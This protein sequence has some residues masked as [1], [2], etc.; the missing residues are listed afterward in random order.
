[1]LMQLMQ[2]RWSE[3]VTIITGRSTIGTRSVPGTPPKDLSPKQ[4]TLSIL[5]LFSSTGTLLCCALPAAL[6]AIAGGSAVVGLISTFP[7]LSPLSQHKG[8]I[9][10]AAGVLI[11]F[12]AL[13]VLRP[14]GQVACAITGGK[15]CEVAG[16]FSKVMLWTS[17]GIYGAGAFMSYALVPIMRFLEG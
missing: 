6:A 13:L 16:S 3:D 11:M 15:G 10:L 7:W 4:K 9:F 5:T 2:H 8:W 17:I 14:K 1:M 12:N